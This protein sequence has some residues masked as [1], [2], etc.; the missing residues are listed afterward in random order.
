[1][2]AVDPGRIARRW[3]AT[4]ALGTLA[5]LVLAPFGSSTGGVRNRT[6]VGY[7][8]DPRCHTDSDIRSGASRRFGSKI[9]AACIEGDARAAALHH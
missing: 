7:A 3:L 8:L 4:F 1:L 9:A 5:P 6:A 2:Q